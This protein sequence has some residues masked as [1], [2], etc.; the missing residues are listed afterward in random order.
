MIVR[1]RLFTWIL[2]VLV[3]FA[4]RAAE[5]QDARRAGTVRLTTVTGGPGPVRLA[6]E[7]DGFGAEL[8]IVNDGKEPLVLSRI[9]VRGDASDPRAPPK[10]SARLVDASLPVAV[11][12]GGSRK[13]AVFWAPDKT[14]RQKQ[15]E[16]H[17]VITT[18]DERAGEVAMGIRAE[19]SGGGGYLLGLLL[20]IPFVGAIASVLLGGSRTAHLATTIALAAQTSVAAWICFRFVPDVTRA[21]GNDGLQFVSHVVC[22]R[23]L[24]LEIHFG[25]DGIGATAMLATSAVALFAI[26]SEPV[27]PRGAQG[28]HAALLVLDAAAI[29]A[30]VSM[31][32]VVLVVFV[33]MA[34]A[35]FPLVVGGGHRARAAAWRATF[36]CAVALVLVVVALVFIVRSADPTFLADGTKTSTTFDL[37]ELSR[38]AFGDRVVFVGAKTCFGLVAIASF[39]FLAAF[40]AH[41]WLSDVLIEAPPAAGILVASAMPAIGLVIFLRIGGGLLPEGMRWASGVVVALGTVSTVYG[42]FEALGQ[43]DLRRLAAAS[44]TSLSGCVML[45]AA[46]LT[47]QGIGGAIVLGTT[48]GLACCAFLLLVAAM[49]DRTK[50]SNADRLGGIAAQTPGWMTALGAASLAQAGLFGSCGA[51]GVLLALFGAL[52]SYAPLAIS[53]AIALVVLAVAHLAPLSHMVFGKLDPEWERSDVLEPYGGRVPELTR[54]EWS[55]IVPLVLIV[56]VLGMWPSPILSLTTGTV[57]DLANRV[58]PPGPDQVAFVR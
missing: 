10:L 33:A 9:A 34:I 28:Y 19:R 44:T 21:D 54:R 53:V 23:A 40:P 7:R 57:R 8:L 36:S 35:A 50:T 48:R 51:W 42:A 12:P 3:L 25:L 27:L 11:P 24:S 38:V 52:S 22:S 41:R 45:G 31:N 16:A 37:P 32:G 5:A 17:V 47:P 58:S 26:A 55:T 39:I 6:P 56:I 13:A 14:V 29:G 30:L 20:G 49:H 18:S 46:S 15:L 4:A 1:W 2:F 43:R